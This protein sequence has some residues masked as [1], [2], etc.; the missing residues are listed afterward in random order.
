MLDRGELPIERGVAVT[1]EDKLRSD[2]IGRLMCE[3][4]VDVGQVAREHGFDPRVFDDSLPILDEMVADGVVQRDGYRVT[5]PDRY[6][7]LVRTAAAAF[8]A[9]LQDSERRHATAV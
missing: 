5:V 8:D 1:A 2:V 3:L 7:L 4:T 6:R 9:Y